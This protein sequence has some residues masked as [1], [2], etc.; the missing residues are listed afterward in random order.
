[1]TNNYTIIKKALS[2]E[3]CDF[4]YEYFKMRRQ[5]LELMIGSRL[6]SPFVNYWGTF[7]DAQIPDSFACYGDP[8][9]DSLLPKLKSIMEKIT[10]LTLLETYTYAR[11]YKQGDVLNRHKD[12]F[13]CEVSA[14]LHL[15]GTKWPIYADKTGG[16]DEEGARIDLDVGDMLVY[17][18]EKIEHCRYPL[19]GE[20]CAQ[21]FLHYNDKNTKHS[22]QNRF[23]G[24]EC[25]GIP[26]CL[27]RKK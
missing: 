1:M 20:E 10:G 13:S 18:G 21:V 26:K 22:K 11:L 7:G 4:L 2:K 19:H 24:R 17:E 27:Q 6:I 5:G 23:D 9:F 15:G 14:T 25:L 12:R 8:A 16:K 3:V